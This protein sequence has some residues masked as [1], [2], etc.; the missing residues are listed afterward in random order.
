MKYLTRMLAYTRLFVLSRQWKSIQQWLYTLPADQEM[1]FAAFVH[2]EATR[3]AKH[4]TPQFY[5]SENVASYSPW[6]DAVDTAYAL[7]RSAD[8]KDQMRGIAMWLAIVYYETR[9]PTVTA[10]HKLHVDVAYNLERFR[11][12]HEHVLAIRHA[13]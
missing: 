5:G 7:S 2:D 4:P 8:V 3:A 9:N 6:G 11:S 1:R 10:L 12:L 13:A